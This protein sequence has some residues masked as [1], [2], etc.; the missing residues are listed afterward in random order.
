MVVWLLAGTSPRALVVDLKEEEFEEEVLT[1]LS[2]QIDFS[3]SQQRLLPYGAAAAA[4]TE[5]QAV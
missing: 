3:R 4:G 5:T 1:S 2:W